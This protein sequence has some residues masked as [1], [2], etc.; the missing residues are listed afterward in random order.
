VVQECGIGYFVGLHNL[1]RSNGLQSCIQVDEENT[2]VTRK[3]FLE[4]A[5]E[6]CNESK[7]ANASASVLYIRPFYGHHRGNKSVKCLIIIM[8]AIL[9]ST[10]L[11]IALVNGI[12]Q[13]YLPRLSNI[14]KWNEWAILPLLPICTATQHFGR[15]RS[16]PKVGRVG[17]GINK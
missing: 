8:S 12:T 6:I 1:Q 4:T 16:F 14:H 15:T 17:L 10:V 3:Y 5:S 13:F 2:A 9:N 11:G 7:L